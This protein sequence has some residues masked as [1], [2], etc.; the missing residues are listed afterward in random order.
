MNKIIEE[1]MNYM[2]EK[3]KY[4]DLIKDKTI[5]VTGATGL[6]A[7]NFVMF[8]CTLNKKYDLNIKVVA[9]VRNVNKAHNVFKDFEDYNLEYIVQDICDPIEYAD[10]I[11]Y[12]FHA[13]GSCSA[14][15]IKK[16]PVGIMKANTLGTINVLELAREKN[17]EKVIFPSTR[18]IYGEVTDV[19]L[20]KE[21]DMGKIDPLNSRNCYP[22][23]KR[24]AE[25]LLK[26][27]YDQYGINFNILRIAH[28]YGPGMAIKNDGRVMADFVGAI[29]ENENIVLNSD[30][31]AV[32]GFC[33]VTDTID[34]IMDVM[35]K[36]KS[37]EAY[38][39]ANETELYM[40]RDVA[41][42]LVDLY[43]ERGL[44]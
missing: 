27:Y 31:T 15:A 33:Y 10:N 14:E 13:A 11:D 18:E 5:L 34:G 24:V 38:N 20:I 23:S 40:I 25:S 32:R 16:D 39:L 1:D 42:M 17:V 36:G 35:F 22:E 12:I 43:P 6:I 28:T 7:K 30:G 44:K 9:L 4:K 21:E 3:F 29:I 8:L 37:A 41:Q 26:S 2:S 19:D